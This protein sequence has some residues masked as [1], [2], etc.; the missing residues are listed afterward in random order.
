ML[1]LYEPGGSRFYVSVVILFDRSQISWTMVEVPCKVK[2]QE[3]DA[4]FTLAIY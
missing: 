4:T 1:L 2:Q 3:P